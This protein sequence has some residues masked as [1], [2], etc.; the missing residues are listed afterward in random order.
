MA[1]KRATKISTQGELLYGIQP[2]L[3]ALRHRKRQLYELFIK[4]NT[5]HSGR[6][7]EL[8]MLAEKFRIPV[9]EMPVNKFS[10]ICPDAV[11]QGVALRCGMLRFSSISE[12]PQ[13]AEDSLSLIVAL[14]QIEDPHNLGAILRTCGFFNVNAVVVSKDHSCGLTPVVS[15]TSAGVAEWLPVISVINLTRFLQ[16]QK[17]KGYWVVGLAEE[18]SENINELV[19]DRPL[20]LVMGNEGRG[21]RPLIRRQCDWIF[22]ISGNPEVSSLNVSNA[23]SIALYHFN[24]LSNSS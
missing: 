12:I 14:D 2:V 16:Q 15:K 19:W 7:N 22:S 9:R 10:E 17:S 3:A 8:R 6:L 13:L 21:I 24:T 20:I 18:S 5:D 1:R 4:K 23:A 11:H